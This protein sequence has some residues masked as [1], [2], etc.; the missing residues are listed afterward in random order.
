M[1]DKR[2]KEDGFRSQ[3][4]SSLLSTSKIFTQKFILFEPKVRMETLNDLYTRTHCTNLRD[5][6]SRH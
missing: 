3:L 4:V 2:N 1:G 6:E 5:S